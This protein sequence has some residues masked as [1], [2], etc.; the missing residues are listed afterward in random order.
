[1]KR[2]I[3]TLLAF[4]LSSFTLTYAQG[5]RVGDSFYDGDLLY[6]VKEVRMGT[7]VYMTDVLGEEELTLEQWGTAPAACCSCPLL[8]LA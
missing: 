7:V 3:I 8:P 2:I 5:I 4:A 6:T 1:M